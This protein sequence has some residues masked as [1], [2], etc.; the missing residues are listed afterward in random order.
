MVLLPWKELVRCKG[1]PNVVSI[2]RE[3]DPASVNT[4]ATTLMGFDWRKL[5][6]VYEAF[7]KH[8][9]PISEIDPQT[10]NIVSDIKDWRGSLDELREKEH[11]D[12]VPYF[13]WKGIYQVT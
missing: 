8:E 6:V 3:R 12:F 10:I 13:G 7:S 1:D 5:P 11:F 9:M 4:V 2:Y